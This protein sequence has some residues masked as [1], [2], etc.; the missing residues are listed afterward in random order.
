MNMDKIQLPESIA[1]L[2]WADWEQRYSE[3]IS[4]F[5]TYEEV[6]ES[7]ISYYQGRGYDMHWERSKSSTEIVFFV[8]PHQLDFFLLTL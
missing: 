1:V 8:P 5:Y 4:N 7:I 6:I 2:M 3:G